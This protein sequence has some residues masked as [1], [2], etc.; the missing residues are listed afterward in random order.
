MDSCSNIVSSEP[1]PSSCPSE[2]LAK[3]SRSEGSN[4]ALSK[5]S[6]TSSAS[7]VKPTADSPYKTSEFYI[8]RV[9]ID[10]SGPETEGNKRKELFLNSKVLLGPSTV[11][12]RRTIL[13]LGLALT[14]QLPRCD[15]SLILLKIAHNIM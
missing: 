3:T 9:S 14:W 12:I 10:A 13:L 8:I 2:K 4:R 6:S 7:L 5:T 1:K 15:T 11:N